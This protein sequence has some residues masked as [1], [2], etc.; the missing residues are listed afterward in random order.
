MKS[1]TKQEENAIIDASERWENRQKACGWGEEMY[2][3]TMIGQQKLDIPFEVELNADN[4]RV[5]LAG[6]LP[7]EKIEER[8]AQNF[9][10]EKG[11][12]AKPGRLAFAALYI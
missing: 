8:Y 2:R 4:R 7:W 6:L 11:E 3:R 1:L 9:K 10:S 12:V 5:K